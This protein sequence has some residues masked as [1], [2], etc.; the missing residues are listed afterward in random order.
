MNRVV[1]VL[2]FMFLF[3]S[4]GYCFEYSYGQPSGVDADLEYII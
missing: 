2:L 3:S 1:V 4:V